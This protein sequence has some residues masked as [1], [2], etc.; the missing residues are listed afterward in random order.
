M[1]VFMRHDQQDRE[2]VTGV[3]GDMRSSRTGTRQALIAT[4]LALL[5]AAC[6]EYRQPDFVATIH[7][8]RASPESKTLIVTVFGDAGKDGKLCTAVASAKADESPDRIDV[9]IV[10]RDVCPVTLAFWESRNRGFGTTTPQD[11]EVVLQRPLGD[12]EVFDAEGS[13]VNVERG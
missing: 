4:A 6:A 2:V 12:R 7:Q 3:L 9:K 11:I 8:L 13:R 5:L 1:A 10:L